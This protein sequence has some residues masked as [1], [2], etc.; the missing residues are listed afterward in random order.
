MKKLFAILFG[1]V[2]FSAGAAFQFSTNA[3][4]ANTNLPPFNANPQYP[5]TVSVY[6]ITNNPNGHL[7]GYFGAVAYQYT[8]T[9]FVSEWVKTTP[10]GNMGWLSTSNSPSTLL[11]DSENTFTAPQHFGTNADGTWNGN[12]TGASSRATNDAAGNRIDTTY[13]P[14]TAAT[15]ANVANKIVQRDSSGNF[16]AAIITADLN[17]LANRAQ[18]DENGNDIADTYLPQAA[19]NNFTL[20]NDSRLAAATANNNGILFTNN[21]SALQS[22]QQARNPAYFI[23]VDDF[24]EVG[25]NETYTA[26]TNT[27]IRMDNLGFTNLGIPLVRTIEDGWSAAKVNRV[28]QWNADNWPGST[29]AATFAHSHGFLTILYI[30]PN[31]ISAGGLTQAGADYVTNIWAAVQQ[32]GMDGIKFEEN[33]DADAIYKLQQA[34]C[35][36]F[37]A[38]TNSGFVPFLSGASVFVQNVAQRPDQ[39]AQIPRGITIRTEADKLTQSTLDWT[40]FLNRAVLNSKLSYAKKLNWFSA[41][42]GGF[43]MDNGPGGGS[44]YE[45]SKAFLAQNAVMSWPVELTGANGNWTSTDVQILTNWLTWRIG[46]AQGESELVE[47]NAT[48]VI[49]AKFMANGQIALNALSYNTNG[50]AITVNLQKLKLLPD[51]YVQVQ[52]AWGATN[53]YAQGSFSYTPAALGSAFLLL[54]PLQFQTAQWRIW[55]RECV[56]IGGTTVSGL[57]KLATDQTESPFFY[58]ESIVVSKTGNWG[59]ELQMPDWTTQAVVTAVWQWS[60]TGN[61]TYTNRIYPMEY[62]FQ[63]LSGGATSDTQG[64]NFYPVPGG[65]TLLTHEYTNYI[66]ST[67]AALVFNPYNSNLLKTVVL[68]GNGIGNPTNTSA[69]LRFLYADV[70]ASGVAPVHPNFPKP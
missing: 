66:N 31:S 35:A 28:L 13:L 39:A 56:G 19:T 34:A 51:A 52:E 16:S 25:T 57:S 38:N 64:R 63:N 58:S 7:T 53:F 9:N 44:P 36:N 62:A 23:A 37:L 50:A 8:G 4:S 60:G 10:T 59:F 22:L 67:T 14:A 49:F 1:A 41:T 33:N 43:Q 30:E 32:Y 5:V 47:S 70:T 17:G 55:P 11:L 61:L 15:N 20:T 65:P 18:N 2:A 68:D 29:A 42:F 45:W 6:Y 46:A 24:F 40:N 69:F 48:D 12:V 21:F 26:F 3:P 54:T 27:I